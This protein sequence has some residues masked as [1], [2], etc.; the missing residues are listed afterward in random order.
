MN[1]VNGALGAS[2]H[3]QSTPLAVGGHRNIP[4]PSAC[5]IVNEKRVN[6]TYATLYYMHITVVMPSFTNTFS[7]RHVLLT[8]TVSKFLTAR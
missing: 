3:T 6:S 2:S 5:Y 8:R 1:K 7:E 4:Y